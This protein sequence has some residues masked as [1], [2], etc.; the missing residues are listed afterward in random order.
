MPAV[1]QL[2]FKCWIWRRTY[3]EKLPFLCRSTSLQAGPISLLVPIHR[4]FTCISAVHHCYWVKPTH[5]SSSSLLFLCLTDIPVSGV[6]GFRHF[7]VQIQ[8]HFTS[9]SAVHHCSWVKPNQSKSLHLQFSDTTGIPCSGV[10]GFRHTAHWLRVSAVLLIVL[11]QFRLCRLLLIHQIFSDVWFLYLLFFFI[12]Y[13]RSLYYKNKFGLTMAP[14]LSVQVP[15]W[16]K[17]LKH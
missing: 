6:E 17:I 13:S 16:E 2:F 11:Q 7:P 12:L 10:E 3:I 14:P 1:V 4:H 15:G 5:S 8:R 9:I